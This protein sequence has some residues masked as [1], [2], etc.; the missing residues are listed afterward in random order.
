[1]EAGRLLKLSGIADEEIRSRVVDNW[2]NYLNEDLQQLKD[3][4]ELNSVYADILEFV[5]NGCCTFLTNL[6]LYISLFTQLFNKPV[7]RQFWGFLF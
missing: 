3:Q 6:S 4:L 2:S 7:N 1:M 5:D